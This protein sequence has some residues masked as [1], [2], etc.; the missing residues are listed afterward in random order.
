MTSITD[1]GPALGRAQ[2]KLERKTMG[3]RKTPLNIPVSRTTIFIVIAATAIGMPVIVVLLVWLR[4]PKPITISLGTGLLIVL[5]KF[6]LRRDTEHRCVR[7]DKA[8]SGERESS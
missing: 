8:G 6:R 7:P 2:H 3:H 5:L 4:V 1:F